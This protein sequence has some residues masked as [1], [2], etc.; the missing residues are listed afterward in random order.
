ML[1]RHEK[2]SQV[3]NL[4][5]PA[6]FLQ[7]HQVCSW[8]WRNVNI[9]CTSTSKKKNIFL[10]SSGWF[11]VSQGDGWERKAANCTGNNLIASRKIG[12]KNYRQSKQNISREKGDYYLRSMILSPLLVEAGGG[13]VPV[14]WA[15]YKKGETWAQPTWIFSSR[16][17]RSHL[18]GFA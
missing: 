18:Y 13:A 15:C 17:G 3:P 1:P 11:Q 7:S 12:F 9:K 8:E 2:H 10:T 16:L 6:I 5:K 4:F 14:L